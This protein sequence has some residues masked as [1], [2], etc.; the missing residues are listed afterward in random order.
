MDEDG[1][2]NFSAANLWHRAVME[3]A[4]MVIVEES[5]GLP[6]AWEWTTVF[7]SARSTTHRR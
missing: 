1:Y 6:Y 3:R 4:K 7:T 5:P 2:F